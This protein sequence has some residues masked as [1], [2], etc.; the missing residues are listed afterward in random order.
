M[1]A[2]AQYQ[3]LEVSFPGLGDQNET[4]YGPYVKLG[5]RYSF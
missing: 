4:L 1:D 2:G 3:F 5:L